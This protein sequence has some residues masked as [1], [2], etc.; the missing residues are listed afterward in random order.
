MA[1]RADACTGAARMNGTATRWPAPD[2]IPHPLASFDAATRDAYLGGHDD[3]E[4][5]GYVAGWRWGFA[6]GG[7]AVALVCCLGAFAIGWLAGAR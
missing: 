5:L 7:L 1:P 2:T 3:G 6:C 4:R